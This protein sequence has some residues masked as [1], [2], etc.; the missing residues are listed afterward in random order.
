MPDL[1]DGDPVPSDGPLSG[2]RA[3]GESIDSPFGLYVHVP[4]CRVRCGYCDFN[5]YTASEL[6]GGASQE[7]YAHVAVDEISRAGAAIR[8]AGLGSRPLSSVFFGG[9][10]PTILPAA[11]L[12]FMLEAARNEWGLLP[13]AEVT[14]EANPDTMTS[15]YAAALAVAGFSRVS[16]GMQSA[17]PHVL[18]TLDRTHSPGSVRTAVDATKAAGLDV[19][20]DLIYGTPGESLDDWKRSVEAALSLEPDHISAYALGIEPGTK[21]GM[22]LRRGL[23]PVP[24]PDDQ[25]TKYEFADAA[26]TDA[27]YPWYEISNWARP[28][29]ECRHNLAYWRDADWWGVGPGAHSHVQGIRFWNVKHPRAYA[30]KLGANEWPV[31]AREVLSAEE[32]E[33]ERVMLQVRLK[34]GIPISRLAAA[35]PRQAELERVVAQ[36]VQQGWLDAAAAQSGTVQLTLRGRL[37]ADAVTRELT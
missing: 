8:A 14:T 9:G 5:T 12:A 2:L 21:M 24:D 18:A 1:P 29:H 30:A 17:V 13:G 35:P 15:N 10:T 37:M 16:I 6:G 33:L 20:V 26:F 4:F 23:I 36:M 7:R 3:P 32:Q 28:G 25:A 27:G 31:A 22:Q 19:S 34:E 11:D